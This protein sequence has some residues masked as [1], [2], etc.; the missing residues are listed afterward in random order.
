VTPKSRF[1]VL[2]FSWGGEMLKRFDSSADEIT[3]G[4]WVVKDFVKDKIVFEQQYDEP[5]CFR[6]NGEF[7]SMNRAIYEEVLPE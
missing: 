6:F 7:D 4:S 3:F 2:R 1:I 5:R